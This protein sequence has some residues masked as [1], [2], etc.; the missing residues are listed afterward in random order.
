MKLFE[1]MVRN[2]VVKEYVY[3]KESKKNCFFC[4]NESVCTKANDY[5]KGGKK[6]TKPLTGENVDKK[7][8]EVG[9]RYVHM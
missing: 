1:R 5:E 3:Y 7:P 8:R 9:M 6:A 2:T 4:D